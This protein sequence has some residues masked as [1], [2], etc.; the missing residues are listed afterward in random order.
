MLI[1]EEESTSVYKNHSFYMLCGIFY[2]PLAIF[3]MWDS[4]LLTLLNKSPRLRRSPFAKGGI[5]D[6]TRGDFLRVNRTSGDC[7]VVP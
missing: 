3:F 6:F 4:A 1:V 7:R 5:G 2:R